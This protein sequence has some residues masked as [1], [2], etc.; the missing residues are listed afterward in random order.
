MRVKIVFP[1]RII[2]SHGGIRCSGNDKRKVKH[3]SLS[4]FFEKSYMI[5]SREAFIDVNT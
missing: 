1:S 3:V 4:Y 2:T 5:K